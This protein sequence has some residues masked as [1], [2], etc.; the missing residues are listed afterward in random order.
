MK[1]LSVVVTSRALSGKT[2]GELAADRATTRGVYLESLK[3]GDEELPREAGTKLERGDVV[4]LIGAPEDAERAAAA[5]G[6]VERDIARTNLTFVA[7]GIV[8]GVLAG[9][10]TIKLGGVPL[11]LGTAGSI[12][13]V[14]LLAGWARSRY[15]VF[16][17]IPAPAQRLMADIGLTVFI[18]VIGLTAGPHAVEAYQKQGSSFFPEHLP[19]GDRG[20]HGP[21]PRGAGVRALGLPHATD[22]GAGRDRGRAD[23]HARPERASRGERQQHRR[24]RL[25]GAYAIGNILL[26][27]WGPLVVALTAQLHT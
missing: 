9:L 3:R 27:L 14:G 19:G 26:T 4:R 16:G 18:A 10:L 21:A 13:V 25:H 11:G 22:D 5:L 20:D 15:P 2:L 8:A 7:A 23:L 17:S 12:L 6:F 1:A 24:A